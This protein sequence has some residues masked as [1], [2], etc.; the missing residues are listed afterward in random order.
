MEEF[1]LKKIL[2][3]KTVVALTIQLAAI[4]DPRSIRYH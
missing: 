1:K 4:V 3:S 2:K